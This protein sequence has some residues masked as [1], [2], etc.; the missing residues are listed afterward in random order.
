M[1]DTGP[2]VWI[3]RTLPEAQATAARVAQLGFTPLIAPVLEVARPK[4]NWPQGVPDAVILTSAHALEA[5]QTDGHLQQFIGL[6]L[7]VVGER[8]KT[9]AVAAG[10]YGRLVWAATA[11]AL[12]TAI[13]AE[14]KPAARLLYLAPKDPAVP[15]A[16]WLTARDFAATSLI[17]YE[18]RPVAP[19]PAPLKDC[20][21]LF[22]LLHS[23]RAAHAAGVYLKANIIVMSGG[24]QDRFRLDV[25]TFICISE[26]ARSALITGLDSAGASG[27]CCYVAATPDEAGLLACLK[28]CKSSENE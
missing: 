18:T 10:F 20:T 15:L 5:L 3:T 25:L 2:P 8:L 23:A 17:V 11:E 14:M 4:I 26:A 27:V 19:H 9:K 28:A 24:L 22:V 13:A 21:P 16:D 1:A 6:P 12:L 7:F